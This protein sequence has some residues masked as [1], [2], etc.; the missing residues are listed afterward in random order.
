MYF[1]TFSIIFC[2]RFALHGT[3]MCIT[4]VVLFVL[5]VL[6]SPS[7]I[8]C[9]DFLFHYFFYF[10]CHRKVEK[11]DILCNVILRVMHRL[12]FIFMAQFYREPCAPH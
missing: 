8:S 2:F 6:L 11:T 12:V 5:I 1:S 9:F 10:K 3:A 4:N 7:I